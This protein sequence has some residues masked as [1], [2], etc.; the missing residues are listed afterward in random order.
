MDKAKLIPEKIEIINFKIIEGQINSPFEFDTDKVEGHSFDVDFEMG[1]NF[2]KKLIRTDFKVLVETK[3][4]NGNPKEAHGKFHFVFVYY[5]ENLEELA[6]L[7][8]DEL[9]NLEHSLANALASISHSTSRG[10]LMTRFQGTALENFIMP[11]I[12]PN[13]LLTK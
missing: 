6:S 11:V 12:D 10:I 4:K 7:D 13:K 8:K 3:S 2:E 5:V 1:F 9:I